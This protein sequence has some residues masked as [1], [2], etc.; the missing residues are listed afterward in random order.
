MS[1]K[2]HA[3]LQLIFTETERDNSDKRYIRWLVNLGMD[4]LCEIE[5]ELDKYEE[6]EFK[7]TIEQFYLD[8]G[9]LDKDKVDAEYC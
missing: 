2:L 5:N 4:E 8:E 6:R 3:I 7:E 9:H 1:I